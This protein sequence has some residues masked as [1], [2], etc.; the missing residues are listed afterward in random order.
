MITLTELSEKLLKEKM[1]AAAKNEEVELAIKY[2]ENLN[3]LGKIYQKRITATS[4]FINAD[5]IVHRYNGIYSAVNLL[6]VR[7]GRMLG[8]KNYSFESVHDSENETVSEFI[9]RYYKEN[10]DIPDEIIVENPLS[11]EDALESYFSEKLQKS[12]ILFLHLCLSSVLQSFLSA[13]QAI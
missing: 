3:S 1:A 7:N 6:V 10:G 8:G 12:V 4:K 13:R 11:D 9:L 2:R 5:V